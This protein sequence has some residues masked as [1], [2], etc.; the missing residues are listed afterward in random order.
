MTKHGMFNETT[1][2]F[3]IQLVNYPQQFAPWGP[4]AKASLAKADSLGAGVWALH[5]NH[6]YAALATL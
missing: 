6:T 5:D 3:S 1:L 2:S 4:G